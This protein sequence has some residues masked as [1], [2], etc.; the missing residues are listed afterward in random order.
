MGPRPCS[1]NVVGTEGGLCFIALQVALCPWGDGLALIPSWVTQ[2]L[3]DNLSFLGQVTTRRGWGEVIG[4]SPVP[5]SHICSPR[6]FP[7]DPSAALL[8]SIS[9]VTDANTKAQASSLTAQPNLPQRQ[10]RAPQPLVQS[11]LA[12]QLYSFICFH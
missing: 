12:G 9:C 8:S 5:C 11:G 10:G 7:R 2:G 1:S 3:Q 4:P 6:P